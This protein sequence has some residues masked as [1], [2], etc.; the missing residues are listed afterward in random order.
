M[1]SCSR[2]KNP[3]GIEIV[4]TED[5]HKYR[6]VIDGKE[7]N[8]T[9]VTGLVG[10]CFP[11]FDPTGAITER[12]A[13]KEGITV[14]E[15]K[16]RWAAK[17]RESC[18]LGTR[19][20]ECCEDIVLGRELRN[21]AE[22][23]IEQM[24]FNNAIRMAKAFRQKLDIIGVEKLVFDDRLK[25]A[26]TIDLLGKSRKNGNYLVLDWKSN[27]SIEQ[28]NKYNKFGLDPIRH[29]PDTAFYH[30][31]L[32]LSMYQFLL[33]F[34]GYV[35]NDANFQRAIIHVT[36]KFAKIIELPDLTSEIK[37]IIIDF[38]LKKRS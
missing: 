14:A 30:Y 10:S 15:L 4:F 8:Y 1:P 6:S 19:M 22:N 26:G 23:A 24:R 12:C 38:L 34:G 20:H 37:D 33:K 13:K 31:S 32:Q 5:D 17:G 29:I 11:Q 7:I 27:A 3:Q 9:S 21:K 28:D 18:R 35:P 25:I 16:E 36:D 2:A